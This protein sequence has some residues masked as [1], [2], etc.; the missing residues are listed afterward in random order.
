MVKCIDLETP[1]LILE[2]RILLKLESLKANFIRIIV[3]LYVYQLITGGVVDAIFYVVS[4][5]NLLITGLAELQEDK[6]V[7]FWVVLLSH[8]FYLLF[9]YWVS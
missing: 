3:A 7:D 2:S 4:G 6:K 9:P 8:Y 5:G 1:L